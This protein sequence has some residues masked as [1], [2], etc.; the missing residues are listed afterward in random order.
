MPVFCIV[1]YEEDVAGRIMG[2]TYFKVISILKLAMMLICVVAEDVE[3]FN[4]LVKLRIEDSSWI[5]L[6]ISYIIQAIKN[7]NG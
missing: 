2:S 1:K 4:K 3:V 5:K 7:Y 6:H